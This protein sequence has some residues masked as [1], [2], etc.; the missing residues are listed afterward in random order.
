MRRFYNLNL[1]G[2]SATAISLLHTLYTTYKCT[3]FG[4]SANN[5]FRI[6]ILLVKIMQENTAKKM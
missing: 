4:Y 1:T 6:R 2:I 3:K 5:V